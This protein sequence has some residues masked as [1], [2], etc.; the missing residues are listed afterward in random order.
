M[1]KFMLCAAAMLAVAVSAH[2][3]EGMWTLDNLPK[4]Q[5]QTQYGFAPD[6]AWTAHV[7]RAAVRLAGGCS[8]SFVSKDGLV[9]TNH[10]CVNDCVQQL[11]SAAKDFIKDGFYAKELKD[12][13]M[14]PEIELNRLD[15]I[16]DTTARVKQATAGLSGEA[17]SKA[18]KAEKSKI[19]A[20]CVAGDKD[21]TRCDVVEL[22]HGGLYH[23]YK[24]HRFQDVR[25]VFAPELTM[26]FFGGDPDNFNFPRYDLDI[27]L[28]RAY[29]DGKPAV[30]ADFFPFSKSG[31]EAGEM[32]MVVGHPGA[33]Q[34]GLTLTQLE[35]LRDLALPQRLFFGSEYR[36]LLTRFR[37]ESAEH[38]RI[39]QHD[40]FGTENSLKARKGMLEALQ[41]PEVFA[42]KRKQEQS[43][44]TFVAAN[45]KLK[46]DAGA[47]DEITR[48]ETVLRNNYWPYRL[49]EVGAGFNCKYF[50]YARTLVRGAVEKQKPNAERL[51]EFTESALP[52]Q[53]QELFSTAP[54]Y[55]DFEQVKLAW[56]LTKLRE[57]LGA[58]DP[59]VQ[60]LFAK[61]SPDAMAARM[62]K[63]TQLGDAALRKL[64][65]QGG[66]DALAKSDD[67]FIQLATAVDPD[68]RAVRKLIED[69]VEAPENKAAEKLA[70]ATF[71]KEGTSVYPDATFTL[72][73]SYGEV[74]GWEEKGKPVAPFTDI[75][76]A[77]TRNTGYDPFKLP[78]S[79]L[80]A[81][82][83]LNGAQRL[84][85][86]TTNDIIGG[87]SGSPMINRNAEIVGLVFDGNIDS[88]GGAFWFDERVNRTVAVHSG[89]LLEAL[90]KVY[91]ARRIVDELRPQ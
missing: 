20:E 24:Y 38:D 11:S 27:G 31:A 69:A 87:N 30:V 40:L 60:K 22:Y 21:K 19:E 37:E 6:Q 36:G 43:L 10:H 51:R 3:A 42:Y 77:F 75:A 28:L 2:A 7:Q 17:F 4:K 83:K 80:A 54:V 50:E 61:E 25:L 76:G 39:A 23:L 52:Q 65:W 56:S 64:L 73:L 84:D 14:C 16:I 88:L 59:F 70:A 72:R 81:K 47:W 57:L 29:E 55:P 12:E 90:D 85:F 34:R 71:A 79:W 53:E 74:K 91:G 18:Q 5:M 78:D 48:A 89:A 58:D 63:T 41:D 66:A 68:A 32:T 33:T 15:A 46:A 62:V 45:A 8:G 9:M 67:P 49:I 86:V 35:T 13:K 44:R 1:P 26:A 82:D